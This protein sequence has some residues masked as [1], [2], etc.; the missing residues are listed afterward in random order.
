MDAWITKRKG[1]PLSVCNA[2][3]TSPSLA[4]RWSDDD[5]KEAD[6]VDDANDDEAQEGGH[7][8]KE[9]H[10]PLSALWGEVDEKQTP[11]DDLE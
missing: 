2:L 7:R 4:R 9:T 10:P 11:A 1:F 3:A 6:D 5:E 8:R